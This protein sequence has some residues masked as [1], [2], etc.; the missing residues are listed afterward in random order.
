MKVKT[1]SGVE[2][3]INVSE[4]I[5]PE[6]MI[7][8]YCSYRQITTLEG[9]SNLINL[10][11]LFCYYN[12]IRTLEPISN[13]INLQVLDCSRNQI[14]TLE[15]I[16]NLINL[17]VLN[18]SMNKI[19][20][21]EPIRNLINLQKLDCSSN[22]IRTLEP[23]TNL[24]NLQELYCSEN[25]ITT[26]EGI[27]NLI[28]LQKLDCAYNLIRTLEP[29]SELNNLQLLYCYSNQITILPLF[30][31]NFRNL[32]KFYYYGNEI[33][34]IPRPVQRLFNRIQ[35]RYHKNKKNIYNDGQNVHNH[36]IQEC[37]RNSINN[38]FTYETKL[39]ED[40][41]KEEILE[42][43]ILEETTKRLLLEYIENKD[44]HS[45]IGCTFE[46]LMIQVWSIIK[47]HHEKDEIKS[48]L[49]QEMSDSLCKCFTGRLSRLVNVLNGY[50][51][52]VSITIS[53]SEQ[54]NMIMS[55]S[56][57]TYTNREELEEYIRQEFEVRG[58]DDVNE[59]IGYLDEL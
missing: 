21:L 24:I 5:N 52:L 16:S 37:I 28:N 19:R 39:N 58:F 34:Y 55:I 45:V 20:T 9:I 4:I 59:W 43:N 15:G 30:L 56:I 12:Q 49:N 51:E 7:E 23:N 26:L 38:L 14:T 47:K 11:R 42:D 22:R 41:L 44:E 17:Q 29:I 48:I 33:E 18:C 35:N 46:D 3:R 31:T 40:N 53:D 32:Q 50:S 54:K 25:K 10:E 57:R 2:Y 36:H 27:S 13:L 6:E 8:L 1:V